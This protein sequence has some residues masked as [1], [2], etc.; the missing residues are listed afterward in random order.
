MSDTNPIALVTGA[1][2]GIGAAIA[3]G[4]AAQGVHVLLGSREPDAANAVAQEIREAGGTAEILALDVTNPTSV[5]NAFAGIDSSHGRLDIL[6]NNAGIA[7]DHWVPALK[8]DMD[9]VRQTM[10]VNVY[11]ALACCQAA[12][13]IMRRHAHGRIVNI[14][15]E[16][17]SLAEM[18][19]AGSLAYRMSKTALNA[20]TRL[21]AADLAE[22]ADIHIN[23][24]C[25][26]WVKTRLGGADAPRTTEEGADT[27]IWLAMQPAGGP[28][29]EL[30][31]DR[32]PYPW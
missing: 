1:N 30:F 14:S 6:V 10:E 13:P 5:A 16:L 25:P 7:L 21:V 2:R 11:G 17:G 31:R 22:D 27:A 9:Q 29:G 26:G 28:S 20:V 8:A 15:S 18:K 19:M 32:Q 4:L 24:A 3:R 23:A 12:I